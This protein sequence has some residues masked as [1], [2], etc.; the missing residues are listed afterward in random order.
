LYQDEKKDERGKWD[1]VNVIGKVKA[2]E[3]KS[4]PG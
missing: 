2:A 3:A 1:C 4:S